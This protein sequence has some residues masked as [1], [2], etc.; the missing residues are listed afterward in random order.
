MRIFLTGNE[1]Y[2]GSVVQEELIEAGH[3]VTGHD[4]GF[5]STDGERRAWD[6]RDITADDLRGHDAIVH[7]AGLSNDAAGELSEDVTLEINQRGSIQ[8]AELAREAGVERFVFAS[9]CSVYGD[10]HQPELT[11]DGEVRPLTAY[12]RSKLVAERAIVALDGLCA[13]A[14]R[15]ATLFG[16]SPAL[17]NDLMVN[18]MVGT[19][20]R[21][22]K[23][24][25]TGDGA[26][27]RPL[28]HVRDAA[29]AIVSTLEAPA[30]A[31][32]GQVFNVGVPGANYTIRSVA[33]LV[34]DRFPAA[35]ISFA[36]SPD[37]RSYTVCFDRF[38]STVT[39]W[40]PRYD[41]EYGI[42]EVAE[43]LE[44][45]EPF[46]R[47]GNPWGRG[48]R[49]SWLHLLRQENVLTDAFRWTRAHS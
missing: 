14:L 27:T 48:E 10:A 19:A 4:A 3:T 21:Y 17:R 29:T 44:H 25:V 5:F 42:R 37:H 1:G 36:G 46:P 35:E 15:F 11:E 39:A 31:V 43:Y 24:T 41:V 23:I 47:I 13:T 30:A 34:T 2:L 9:S 18:R 7:L 26:A 12:A 8:L 6:I 28:L 49:S 38:T 40:Q 16:A 32:R 33:E 22:G 20:A 45:A